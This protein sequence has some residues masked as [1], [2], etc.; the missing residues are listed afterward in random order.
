M[1][2]QEMVPKG[3]ALNVLCAV[4]V[5]FEKLV[6]VLRL[7]LM[8]GQMDERIRRNIPALVER[9]LANYGAWDAVSFLLLS[10][11]LKQSAYEKW[12]M[13]EV[14]YL[15]DAVTSNDQRVLDMLEIGLEHARGMGLCSAVM[16]W[17]GWGV[18]HP[19]Q[20][21]RDQEMNAK[22]Q[23]RLAPKKNRRQLDL[24]MDAPHIVLLN[25][26]RQALLNRS[27]ERE[28]LFDRAMNELASEPALIRLD[29][30]RT[31]ITTPRI[32]HPIAWFDHLTDVIM[33]AA[34]DEF[35]HR[36]MDIMASLWRT[37]A[38]AMV[39]IDFDPERPS[40]HASQAFLHANAWESCLESVAQIPRWF[41]HADL[42][43][44]RIA[45]LSGMHEHEAETEAW[46]IYCWC[47]PNAAKA[48]LIKADL[49]GCGLHRLWKQFS[50]LDPKQNIEDFPALIALQKQLNDKQPVI[51]EY[52]QDTLGW[53]HYQQMTS[54]LASEQ[55]GEANIPLRTALKTSSP[56]LFHTF[57]TI[58]A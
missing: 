6:D 24:F 4:A 14:A 23:V 2:A 43:D 19:L 5:H 52:A 7:D 13:G 54:L 49:Y 17:H 42:H 57:L 27:P 32:D 45:A 3:A 50:Q 34:L 26:V 39:H 53:H 41:E 44:R 12:R 22:F 48:A 56:W 55:H 25:R 31:A 9:T 46:M 33:P 16:T 28:S 37:A 47:C 38:N 20:L 51:F 18:A 58:H 10:H 21:F 35:P 30:I 15:E 8:D 36:S 11:S 1:L 29:A 40:H